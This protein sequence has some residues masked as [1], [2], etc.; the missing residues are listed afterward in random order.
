MKSY[1]IIAIFC[2]ICQQGFGQFKYKVR[3]YNA[4]DGFASTFAQTMVQDSLGFLWIQ[5]PRGLTCYDGYNF[6]V[7]KYDPDNTERSIGSGELVKVLTD[8]RGSL[9][10]F[11]KYEASSFTINNYDRKT[12]RFIKYKVGV[13]NP[14][15]INEG[16][17]IRSVRFEKSGG[18]L[19]IAT[20][21]GLHSFDTATGTT[22]RYLNKIPNRAG[23]FSNNHV[24]DVC[25]S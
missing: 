2:F 15:Q 9:W 12:D 6:Y 20:L 7:Y 24:T 4:D 16:D 18:I 23:K 21:G 22:I 14:E 8:R 5:H 25:H 10:V 3:H 17:L 1:F 11:G 19:W 13:T